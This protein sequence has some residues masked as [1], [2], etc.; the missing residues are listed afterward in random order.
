M[1]ED[2]F[3]RLRGGLTDDSVAA[4]AVRSYI[5]EVLLDGK[6][7][8]LSPLDL[9]ICAAKELRDQCNAALK[10]LGE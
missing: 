8:R 4:Q 7:L 9:A 5:A 3:L 10:D 2:I 6:G 1:S